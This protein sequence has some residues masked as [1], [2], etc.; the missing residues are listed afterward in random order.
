MDSD[1]TLESSSS[2]SLLAFLGN[3]AKYASSG[4]MMNACSVESELD[5]ISIDRSKI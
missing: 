1:L 2:L 4:V 3:D 5:T